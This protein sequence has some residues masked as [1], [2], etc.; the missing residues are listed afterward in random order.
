LPVTF[1][2]AEG[3][4]RQKQGRRG[5]YGVAWAQSCG[6]HGVLWQNLR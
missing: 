4:S 3:T 1:G 6:G 5:V 2:L